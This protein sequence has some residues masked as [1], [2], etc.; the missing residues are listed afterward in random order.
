M[1]SVKKGFTLIEVICSIFILGLALVALQQMVSTGFKSS[2]VIE[3]RLIAYNL[4]ERKMESLQQAAFVGLA[5]ETRVEISGFTDYDMAVDVTNPVGGDSNLTQIQITI[6]WT[7]ALNQEMSETV[8]TYR[9][10][11]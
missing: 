4:L 8:S 9:A 1:K 5:D 6:Y 3:D 11:Y 7:N 10:N 2:T